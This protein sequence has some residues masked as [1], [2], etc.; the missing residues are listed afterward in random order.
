MKMRLLY[1]L[2]FVLIIGS[3]V[4]WWRVISF[5]QE[6]PVSDPTVQ[7]VINRSQTL[8]IGSIASTPEEVYAEFDIFADFLQEQ[9]A[10]DQVYLVEVKPYDDPARAA[11]EMRQGRLDVFIDSAFPALEVADL[12]EGEVALNRWK[13]GMEKRSSILFVRDDSPVQTLEEFSGTIFAFEHPSSTSAYLLPKADLYSHGSALREMSPETG[14]PAQNEIGYYFAVTEDGVIDDV[15]S[16]KAGAGALGSDEFHS[17]AATQEIRAVHETAPVYRHLVVLRN[18]IHLSVRSALID[19][20]LTLDDTSEG[21]AMLSQFG[22]TTKFS[23]VDPTG[24]AEMES[25]RKLIESE[26]LR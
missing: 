3:I 14:M 5:G 23:A 24:L 2:T 8:V 26:I 6:T 11:R 15:L 12:A 18:D 22:G 25:L 13:G 19:L 21:R 7:Q 20:L 17:F 9:L 10:D 4:Y 1:V 16:G